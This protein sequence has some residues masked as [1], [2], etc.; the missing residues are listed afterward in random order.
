MYTRTLYLDAIG[1]FIAKPVVKVITG[2]R[3]VGKSCFLRQIIDKLKSDGVP[4]NRIL[5]INKESLDFEFIANHR[6]LNSFV[7]ERFAN[8]PGA[9]YLFVDEVHEI[10]DWEKAIAS[11]SSEGNEIDIYLTG[12]NAHM[13]SSELATLLS[14]R[15]VEFPIYSLGLDEFILFRNVSGLRPEQEFLNYIRFGGMPA[16][17]KFDLEDETVY[18]YISSVYNTILLKDVVKRNRVRN[19]DL[20][21]RINRYV[22]DN[23]G[24]IFSAKAIA[25]YLKSQR[26]KVGV[27]TVQNYIGYL[28]SALLIH[29]VPR[30]DIKGKRLLEIHEKYYLGD[31]GMRHALLGYREA[32]I[33]GILENIV[34]LELKR[35]GYDVTIGALGD[36]EIDFIATRNKE[37]MYLQVSYL[38]AT[39]ET[40]TR[41][42]APLQVVR[43]NYPKCVLSMDTAFGEDI[44]GIQRLNL[45][46]FLLRK[47][48]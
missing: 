20:L 13:F 44:A 45:I 37:K 12:S 1:P 7:N 11:L 4:E 3:R 35:R 8:I 19:V 31:I 32:D 29:K 26:L 36:K 48:S 38:L 43:D 28:M 27:D 21:E 34:F 22:F 10:E 16:V 6:D 17:H 39:P 47:P 40:V 42:F 23:T 25:D 30:Y 2:M 15:Y 5:S 14:G 41:E 46:D 24:N 9:K 18:Q 33:S